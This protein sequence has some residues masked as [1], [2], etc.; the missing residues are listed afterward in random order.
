MMTL[1]QEQANTAWVQFYSTFERIGLTSFY[2][3]DKLKDELLSSPCA[4]NEEMGT[5]YKGA[6]LMHINMICA[7]SQRIS[8]MISGTFG[9]DDISLLKVC[10]IMH[11]SKRFLYVENENEWEI[12]N[13]GL[14]FKFA[15]DLEGVLK[16]GERSALEALNN[17]VK[18]SPIEYEAIKC[19][20]EDDNTKN[21][22][23]SILTTIIKQANELAYAIEK[24]KYNKIVNNK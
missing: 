6:L 20:D 9:V 24:E 17:G 21:P 10:C 13:R 15:K 16:G 3:M 22:Y 18:I 19:L 12:K 4:I 23:K 7:L 11:L 14:L 8:K 5:A 2:D 1:S